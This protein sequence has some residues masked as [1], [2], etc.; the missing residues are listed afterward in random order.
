M[1]LAVSPD[2]NFFISGSCDYSAK[3]WDIREGRCKQTFY[4]H[5][6]DINA[7]G[8]NLS[9]FFR[10]SNTHN[11]NYL[12]FSFQH[13]WEIFP[14]PSAV[15]PQ[16][17]CSDHWLRWL[18]LQAVRSPRRS[19]AG[20]LQGLG[21]D[22]WCHLPRTITFWTPPP[23]WLRRL[24]LQHLGHA[25]GRESG[26]VTGNEREAREGGRSNKDRGQDDSEILWRK[27]CSDLAMRRRNRV[28]WFRDTK[29]PRSH[30]SQVRS[31]NDMV[32]RANPWLHIWS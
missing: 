8:V 19:G 12:F 5:E 2:F 26:W 30:C 24:H 7:I 1:S 21:P 25:E 32:I 11:S 6:S 10:T 29:K 14:P 15:L 20:Y 23:G 16:W 22:E 13:I 27:V 31:Q 9:S 28:C 18:V 4:G 3:L 17:Q